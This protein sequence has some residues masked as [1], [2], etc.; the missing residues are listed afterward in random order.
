MALRPRL[1]RRQLA[2]EQLQVSWQQGQR[3]WP[4]GSLLT[5]SRFWPMRAHKH[6][7]HLGG[8]DG[9]ASQRGY[10]QPDLVSS[11]AK[12]SIRNSITMSDVK[13]LG[14]AVMDIWGGQCHLHKQQGPVSGALAQDGWDS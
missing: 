13:G 9:I 2:E 8:Q 10:E 11:C 12:L 14:P 7:P 3:Q 5:S 1:L 4:G 6:A